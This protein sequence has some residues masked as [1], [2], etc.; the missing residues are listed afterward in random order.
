ME[1]RGR[2]EGGRGAGGIGRRPGGNGTTLGGF[3]CEPNATA[4]PCG[5]PTGAG[6]TMGG[7]TRRP[8]Y[9]MEGRGR[10]E[11]G[12]G[13]GGMGMRPGGN[14][15]TLGGFGCEPNATAGPCG[16]PTGAGR[17]VGGGSGVPG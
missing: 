13:A 5:C 15:T 4:V 1:G 14:G 10:L 6:R 9:L 3:G 8:A 16:C 2:L 12:R 17:T 7:A 11:G